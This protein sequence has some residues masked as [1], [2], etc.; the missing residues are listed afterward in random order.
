M[1][2]LQI[3][4]VMG[5][6]FFILIPIM[7]VTKDEIVQPHSNTQKAEK[8]KAESNIN[9]LEP[10]TQNK[11]HDHDNPFESSSSTAEGKVV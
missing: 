9:D 11:L 7:A 6:V 2:T 8:I 1:Q 5:V 4:T 10:S 3:V